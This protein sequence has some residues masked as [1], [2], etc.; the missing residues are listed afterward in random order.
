MHKETPT[1]TEVLLYKLR[2]E[3]ALAVQ[4]KLDL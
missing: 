3:N 2:I 4:Y 1:L